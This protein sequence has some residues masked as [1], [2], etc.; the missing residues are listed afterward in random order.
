MGQS[1][2]VLGVPVPSGFFFL[3]DQ[4]SSAMPGRSREDPHSLGPGRRQRHVFRQ[5]P[6]RALYHFPR[7]LPQRPPRS[8]PSRL[9]HGHPFF[10]SPELS[11]LDFGTMRYLPYRP[12]GLDL[13]HGHQP[14]PTHGLLAAQHQDSPRGESR[15]PCLLR[16][17]P[18]CQGLGAPL[19]TRPS[20]AVPFPRGV[21]HGKHHHHH[22]SG[23]GESY[24]T[25]PSGYLPDGPGSDSSSGP[26]HGSSSDSVLNCTDV[27]LQA[28]HGSRS[29]F[30]S[31]LSSDYDP[32]AFCTSEKG[33]TENHPNPPSAR[34]DLWPPVV[35]AAMTGRAPLASSH[36]HYHH[37]HHRHHHYGRSPPDCPSDRSSQDPGPR[38]AK[39]SRARAGPLSSLVQKRTEKLHRQE[40]GSSSSQDI[41]FLRPSSFLPQGLEPYLVAMPDLHLAAKDHTGGIG[42]QTSLKHCLPVH[43]NRGRWKG[44]QDMSQSPLPENAHVTPSSHVPP[45]HLD[46]T[47]GNCSSSAEK[48]PLLVSTS[49]TSIHCL[50]CAPQH[51]SLQ[52]DTMELREQVDTLGESDCNRPLFPGQHSGRDTSGSHPSA[53]LH[54]QILQHLQGKPQP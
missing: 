48:Q 5:H 31:S 13:P 35:D 27:S 1:L 39:Y 21:R 22:S 54:C 29:T 3:P 50:V 2:L 42:S 34:R 49:P 25:E 51:L 20:R 46:P 16:H 6:R 45:A 53:Y 28:L 11:Q 38:K 41:S 7:T 14:P 26:C 30:H 17:H 12:A 40:G 8:C 36:V 9:P 52:P 43:P 10:H 4:D 18:S 33:A 44:P 23:S 15:Q 47:S 19:P 32:F 37:H 24:F